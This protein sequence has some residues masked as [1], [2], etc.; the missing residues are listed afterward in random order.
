MSDI[1]WA[2]NPKRES[3]ID[4]TRRMR[5]HADEIFTQRGI[6]LRFTAPDATDSPKLGVDVRRDLLLIF[7]EAVNNAACHSRSSRVSIDLRVKCTW[8]VLTVTDDGAGFDTSLESEGQGLMSMRRRARRL[9]GTIEIASHGGSGTI[10]T[11]AI[12][13]R[14][15]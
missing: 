2:I 4:L 11:T 14:V 8:L 6:E 10:V 15:R 1:V 13:L 9:K 7:K 12:P 3:L 5:Q